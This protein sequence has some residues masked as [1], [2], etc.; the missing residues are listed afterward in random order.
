MGLKEIAKAEKEKEVKSSK[1]KAEQFVTMLDEYCVS[2]DDS[3]ASSKAIKPSSYYKCK[4]SIWY[5]LLEFPAKGKKFARPQ[6]I[7]AIGTATHEWV[8]EKILMK[9]S[10][11]RFGI[12]L[13][14]AEEMPSFKQ[15]GIEFIKDHQSPAMELKFKDYRH[16]KKY[17]ISAMIDGAFFWKDR[18]YL[19]EFKTIKSS[20]F[21]ELFEPQTDHKLQG[22]LYSLC[23][24]IRSIIF[25]YINKDT[26]GWKAFI[27]DYT[28]EQ[29]E[30][31]KEKVL[32][33]ESY[34]IN[35]ELPP[36]EVD[37]QCKW[38]GF[39][40]MCKKDVGGQT[41]IEKDGY[42]VVLKV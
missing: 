20:G 32:E 31:V 8:Q 35:L 40:S 13:L 5:E 11:E 37:D 21:D 29:I 39:S 27:V 25:L 7:F 14:T 17:P 26:Q 9:M 28:E 36:K 38:C 23:L 22:L 30:W 19:F 4:R 33:I 42:T 1:T 24:G 18:D 15:D 10:R 12:E 3:H 41:F 2:S 6:R 34:I 16:T